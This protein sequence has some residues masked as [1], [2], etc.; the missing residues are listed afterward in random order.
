MIFKKTIIR[1]IVTAGVILLAFFMVDRLMGAGLNQLC[2]NSQ[3]RFSRLYGGDLKPDVVILGNSRGVNACYVPDIKASTSL[4]PINLSYNGMSMK[5]AGM[6]FADY[7]EKNRKPALLILEI[8]NLNA[9]DDLIHNL[10]QYVD[11]SP[12]LGGLLYEKDPF[13]YHVA[14]WIKT[15]KYNSEFFLRTLYFYT[16]SDQSWINRYTMDRDAALNFSPDAAQQANF[17]TI[18]GDE[19]SALKSILTLAGENDI[20]VRL[21]I[22]PYLPN[23]IDHIE[24]YG[25]WKGKIL[26]AVGDE[27]PLWDYA[28]TVREL[29]YFADPVHLN[30]AGSKALLEKMIVDGFYDF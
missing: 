10:K 11:V 26:Q 14:K 2:L 27:Y 29:D 17:E 25:A 9:D 21:L 12:R 8:T 23:L 5:I 20:A 24:G 16:R 22:S 4:N 18:D 3:I 13:N 19:L 6:L 30:L 28:S 1:N 15:Y 7:L